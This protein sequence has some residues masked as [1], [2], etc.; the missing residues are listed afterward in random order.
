MKSSSK[1][2]VILAFLFIITSCTPVSQNVATVIPNTP[3]ISPTLTPVP[4][5]QTLIPPTPTSTPISFSEG[6]NT[7]MIEELKR[8]GSGAVFDAQYSPTGD[9]VAYATAVGVYLFDTHSFQEIAFFPSSTYVTSVAFTSDGKTIAYGSYGDVILWDIQK[10][11]QL[12]SFTAHQA[13]I[14][15]IAISP[16]GLYLA[17]SG[18]DGKSERNISNE[19]SVWSTSDWSLIKTNRIKYASE[20]LFTPDSSTL[21]VVADD[22]I[23]TLPCCSW[24]TSG[25][26]Q[27]SLPVKRNVKMTPDIKDIDISQDGELLAVA[28]NSYHII[29]LFNLPSK[30]LNQLV[31]INPEENQQ[32]S[33]GGIGT[34]SFSETGEYLAFT[35]RGAGMVKITPDETV[36][37]KYT[38]DG[39]SFTSSFIRFSPTENRFTY[40]SKNY[41]AST[42]KSENSFPIPPLGNATNIFKDHKKFP[43]GNWA[44]EIDEENGIVSLNKKGTAD[45]IY[46]VKAHTPTILAIFSH[47]SYFSVG[48]IAI[49]PDET[50]FVTGGYDG[51]VYLW[52]VAEESNELQLGHLG[53]EVSAVAISPEG[54]LVAA[55]YGDGKIIIWD[56]S[57]GEPEI[58]FELKHTNDFGAGSN[59]I[60]SIAFSP[61]GKIL[62]S[63]GSATSIKMW[64]VKDGTLLE[65]LPHNLPIEILQFSEDGTILYSKSNI[66]NDGQGIV[67]WWGIK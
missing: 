53:E 22:R 15:A 3:T 20:L 29:G 67:R 28:Y 58:V 60:A 17:T 9:I 66:Y 18:C 39:G 56:I 6:A 5:T 46:T 10:N 32:P 26:I 40:D 63:G 12:S 31:L 1:F 4:P 21:F 13:N 43:S 38:E 50:F 44:L 51:K 57:H 52:Q 11:E 34:V 49:S 16:D 48:D 14:R 24:G 37:I 30:R 64:S 35:T 25:L 65:T 36:M 8:F 7:G 23:L 54:T 47:R 55:G 42:W 19:V 45:P 2:I 33:R 41:N 62:V 27:E 61:D 59:I